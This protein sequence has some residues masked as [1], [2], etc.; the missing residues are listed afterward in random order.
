MKTKFFKRGASLFLAFLMCVTMFAGLSTSAFAAGE[1]GMVYLDIYPSAGDSSSS[2]NW[3]HGALT[4]MNGW[5][6][7][8]SSKFITRAINSFTGKVCYCIEPGRP[9]DSGSYLY[10]YGEDFWNNI[11]SNLNKTLEPDE[12]KVLIGR[13][14]QYG[15]TGTLDPDW[16][17]QNSSDADKLAHVI[18]TQ[19]LIWET[20]VGERDSAFKHVSTGSYDAVY[21][22][23]NKNHPLRSR[24]DSY[25][26]SIVKGVQNHTTV[27]SFTA[28]STAKADTVSLEWNGSEYSVTLTDSNNVLSN[29]N[30]SGSGL[31]FS[32]SGNKLTV[33]SKSAP[34]G[35][36]TVSAEKTNS[37]RKGLIT[38]SD[39]TFS[40]KSGNQDIVC[41]T[42]GVNDPVKAFLKVDVK[43]GN[44]KIAKVSDD[45]RVSGITFTVVGDGVNETVKTDSS[46]NIEVKNLKPGT[47]TVTEKVPAGYLPQDPQTVTVEAG[48][49]AVVKFSNV[50]KRGDLSVTKTSDDGLVEGMKFHLYGTSTSGVK[51]DEYAVTND[52]GVAEF[53]NILIGD[54]Y[55]LE[56]VE[57]ADRYLIPEKQT[58]SVEW[59]KATGKSVNN[60]LKHGIITIEKTGEVFSF[61]T[62]EDGLF[63]PVYEE[64]GLADATYEIS[65][66]GKVVDTITTGENGKASSKELDFGTYEV[67]ETVAPHGMVLN[68]EVY[69]V[70]LSP[71]SDQVAIIENVV[72]AHDNRQKL[73][74]DVAK[75]MEIDEITGQ[76]LNGEISEV[77][78]GLYAAEDIIAADGSLIPAD[79]LIESASVNEDGK[80]IFNTDLPLGKYYIQEIAT[81]GDY[82]LS[83]E[84]Y[85]VDFEYAD[86]NVAT[87]SISANNGEPVENKLI[88]GSV[89]TTKVD[90]EYPENKL[91]GAVFEV[92]FDADGN[93]EF[94]AETDKIVGLMD[95][96][97]NGVYRMDNLHKGGYF[98]HEKSAP[99]GF[100]LDE[101]YYFFEISVDGEVVQVENEAGVGFINKPI[102]SE[103]LIKKTDVATGELLPN[104]GFRIKDAEGNVV[105]EGYTDENGIAEFKLRYGKYTYEEFDAPDGYII[106]TTPHPFEVC[107]DGDIIKAEMTNK[108][109]PDNPK[110]GDDSHAGIWAA[111]GV[112]ALGTAGVVAVTE[113]KKKKD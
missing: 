45:G 111:A 83:A 66:D 35:V 87:V 65:R 26:D 50:A 40:N 85:P 4:F 36:V 97:E 90:A 98:M 11:P 99:E 74:I 39:G 52:K 73:E 75:T 17:T 109:K 110:T 106:D 104:A 86:Q 93:G 9:Q 70:E 19:M 58:V 100:L 12:I 15:Y 28:K 57:T 62:E 95:E 96:T 43:N 92:W 53:K 22:Q 112:L 102:T 82:V 29:Y 16:K 20:I 54:K 48:K 63:Q 81:S 78:F 10:S 3:S 21:D 61:V 2:S 37:L 8:G 30:F 34:S 14:M 77:V 113:L 105:V 72:A 41:Y 108:K 32:K 18:A 38:W 69:T 89:T 42:E 24:I 13:I 101:G 6:T 76:G 23:V 67:R 55:T 94:D 56:E 5:S 7:S 44:L 33:S 84:K 79:G 88:A 31:S 27:P 103:L 51:V 107:K 59:N 91:S 68:E 46:G 64:K 60:S 47:Y 49:T 1:R 80:I 25:Y 71:T